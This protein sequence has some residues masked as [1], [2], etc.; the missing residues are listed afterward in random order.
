MEPILTDFHSHDSERKPSGRNRGKGTR[1]RSEKHVPQEKDGKRR[2]SI[3]ETANKIRLYAWHEIEHW[4][5][6]NEFLH[7]G[8]RKVSN[9]YRASLA[10]LAYV[11]NQ[12]AN[13]YSHLLGALVFVAGGAFIYYSLVPRYQTADV[14]DLGIFA[15]FFAG[16]FI[17]FGFSAFFH[18][19]GN[20]SHRVYH[21]WL[22][23]DLYGILCLICGTVYSGTY[24]GFYCE[25]T[26]WI[27]YSIEITVITI[28]GG[29]I[30]TIPRFRAPKWRFVRA[31]VFGIILL[32]GA[33]PMTHA[34][35]LFGREQA[36]LQMGWWWLVLEAGL[37]V[38]GACIYATR[39]PECLKPGSFDIWG[40]SHQVFH[41]FAVLGA[42][43]HLIGMMK[44]FDYN[45]NPATRRSITTA[46]SSSAYP[47]EIPSKPPRKIREFRYLNLNPGLQA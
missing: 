15:S 47:F 28:I 9:S 34:A 32:S 17:C 23:L 8:Y 36:A 38:T 30:F 20:H 3:S 43:V 19:V 44:A 18:T 1:R 37:Y 4:Q 35:N 25:P 33:V 13:I 7:G 6:D 16:A 41:I 46:T 29:L 39:F 12:T 2:N 11:H 31:V 5:Q 27:T 42:L 45:H 21:N 22:L 40:N 14:Y 10:S 26:A 24:Y